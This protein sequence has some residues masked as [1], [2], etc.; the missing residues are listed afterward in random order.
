MTTP[1]PKPKL[2]VYLRQVE[3][4]LTG[5]LDDI[6]RAKAAAKP[7]TPQHRELL[8]LEEAALGTVIAVTGLAVQIE[9]P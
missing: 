3:K 1:P 2:R 4:D 7:G 6:R 5:Y 8:N 9:K